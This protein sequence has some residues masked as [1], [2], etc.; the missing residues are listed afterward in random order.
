[1]RSN[2][3][4]DSGESGHSTPPA[5]AAST[6]PSRIA[7]KRLP[8]GH[9]P[10][11]TGVGGGQ[12]RPADAER[13]PEVGRRRAAEHGERESRRHAAGCRP[14]CI[15]RA[16]PRRTR[17]RRARCPGRCPPAPDRRG[18]ASPGRNAASARASRPAATRELAE[19]VQAPRPI[20]RPCG[21]PA[22]S[23]RSAPRPAT[24]RRRRRNGRWLGWARSPARRP[25]RN[26]STP[27]PTAV[28]SPRP[29]IQTA[30]AIGHR[31]AAPPAA[32][33]RRPAP[34]RCP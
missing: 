14:P 18:R 28:T 24:G 4:N 6:S 10:R 22:R 33:A 34:R 20:G 29:V 8:Q 32:S 25:A 7:A 16:A 17:C 11:G 2:A 26:A 9:R 30:T 19:S 13:D 1:M 31:P 27:V 12:D 15:A 21:R 5:R 23:R 3:P